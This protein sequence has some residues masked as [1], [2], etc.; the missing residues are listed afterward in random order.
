MR[1]SGAAEERPVRGPGAGEEHPL[2]GPGAGGR[3]GGFVLGLVVFLLFAIGVA[4]AAGYQMVSSALEMSTQ[5]RDGQKALVVARAGL[6]RF[7]GEQIGVVGDSVSYA[8]GDGIA[9]VTTRKVLE[10]DSLNHLYFIRSEGNVADPR[11]PLDP[12]TRVVG[13]YAWHRIS[14]LPHLGAMVSTEREVRFYRSSTRV[15]GNDQATTA[16]CPGGGTAGVAGVATAGRIRTSSGARV[17]GNPPVDNSYPMGQNVVDALNI[18]WDILSD[19]NFPVEFEGSPPNFAAL[20]PDSFPI[21]RYNGNLT[22]H[23]YWSGR[24]V[25]IV[26]GRFRPGFALRWDGI[27]LAGELDRVSSW[28]SP[29]IEG[30]LI[31]G[32]NGQPNERVYSGRYYYH[33]CNVYKANRALS[34]LEVVPGAVFEVS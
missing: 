16:D 22:A 24:G 17:R 32:I 20:P 14:P 23:W 26:T 29:R 11:A 30:M 34:Y 9:T 19:P 1:G 8:I 4:G 12:A 31:A 21:V 5:A 25:L 3:E 28:Y 13:T 33:S 7:L 6:Q 2:R 10:Q 27:I 15:D 18:R